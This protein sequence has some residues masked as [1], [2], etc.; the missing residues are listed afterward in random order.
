[1]GMFSQ[2]LEDT[3]NAVDDQGATGCYQKSV[4]SFAKESGLPIDGL[5]DVVDHVLNG[6]NPEKVLKRLQK[7]W[8]GDPSLWV[9][10]WKIAQTKPDC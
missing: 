1:M 8:G 7:S 5:W 10:W 4:E 6:D 2:L 9:Q 3:R